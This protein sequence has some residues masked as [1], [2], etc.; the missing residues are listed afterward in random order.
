[1]KFDKIGV[2][3]KMRVSGLK[4][5][6][7]VLIAFSFFCSFVFSQEMAEKGVK[8]NLIL[9]PT[10][11][12][13]KKGNFIEGLK[14]E[15]FEVY[16]NGKRQEL[17][18]FTLKKIVDGKVEIKEIEE[19]GNEE[20][21]DILEKRTIVIIFDHVLSQPFHMT[22]IKESLENFFRKFLVKNDRVVIIMDE[23]IYEWEDEK[24]YTTSSDQF[25]QI[26]KE[27]LVKA[28]YPQDYSKFLL[29]YW[30]F[31][32]W[33]MARII[34][35]SNRYYLFDVAGALRKI[36]SEKKIV[37]LSEGGA[38][39]LPGVATIFNDSNCQV[40]SF[41][42][43]GLRDR[44]FDTTQFVSAYDREFEVSSIPGV[45]IISGVEARESGI[46]YIS[47][48]SSFAPDFFLT[49]DHLRLRMLSE[50]TGG[51]AITR[52]N[53]LKEGFEIIGK[54]MSKSYIL[55]YIPKD[56]VLDSKY[57]KINKYRKI[58]VKVN[59]KGVKVLHR[60]GYI[61]RS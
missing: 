3:V 2:E 60:K 16:D 25:S 12:L 56:K 55:G 9:V 21:K 58:K 40:Y 54:M 37:F 7:W 20:F 50:D 61:A 22:Q 30:D 27:A 47:Y 15:D 48:K 4:L 19:K 24:F 28:F 10:L 34:S 49:F 17:V 43:S 32:D 31:Y 42:L 44:N 35:R 1:M 33:H 11:V 23:K 57:K 13:D 26:V 53:D 51:I 59:K 41:D 18:L 29:N 5:F 38:S 6:L 46:S 8:G 36:E 45:S 52:K 39:V 14:K